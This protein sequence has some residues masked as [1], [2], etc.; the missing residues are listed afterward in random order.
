MRRFGAWRAGRLAACVSVGFPPLQSLCSQSVVIYSM[1]LSQ[2]EHVKASLKQRCHIN[3]YRIASRTSQAAILLQIY[4]NL[5]TVYENTFS[6]LVLCVQA[7]MYYICVRRRP[8][9]STPSQSAYHGRL[10]L[11][12]PAIRSISVLCQSHKT[13]LRLFLAVF[14]THQAC[15]MFT[16]QRIIERAIE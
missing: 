7:R 12:L 14:N 15:A 1:D 8:L 2:A 4:G 9:T 10:H 11:M 3:Q 13:S 16:S 5:V 6:Y